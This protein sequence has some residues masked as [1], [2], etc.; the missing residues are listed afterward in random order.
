MEGGREDRSGF[1]GQPHRT[2]LG[3]D[4]FCR[5]PTWQRLRHK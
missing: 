4:Q 3:H 5:L 1:H 2:R